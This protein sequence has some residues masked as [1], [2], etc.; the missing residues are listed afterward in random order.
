MAKPIHLKDHNIDARIV[1]RR[2]AL[3][4]VF[5][6]ALVGALVARMYYL[7][8]TQ[9]EHHSTLSEN[10]RVHV[11][12]IPPTRGRIY[13][14]NGVVLAE[15]RP[16][17][18]L[19]ITRDRVEDLPATFELLRSLLALND[20]DLAQ[21]E[22]RLSQARRPFESVP[23]MFEL[24]Q[25]QIARIAI[26]QFRLPGVEVQASF[27]RYYPYA[28]HFAHALGY[29]GRINEQELKSIDPVAYAGT[30]YIGKTG[31][32]RFYEQLL[33]G[34]VGYE[35]VETNARG[36]VL[37][38]L[39]RTE[40]VSGSDLTL[41]LDAELQA[42]AEEALGDRRGAVVAIDPNTGGVL[43]FVS[44]PGFDP[45]LFV[46]GISYA[47]YG[48]LRD[49]LD[50][51]LF[52]RVLRGQ[53]PPGSTIKPIV[54]L[55]GLDAGVVT[56]TSRVYD[57]GFYQL[58]NVS[59]KYR[60]WNRAGDGW[61]DMPYAIARSNDTYFYDLAHK[62]GIDRLHDF[63]SQF[64]IGQRVSID[65]YEEAAGLM[66][67]R[68]W[69]RGRHRQPWYPGETL[70]AGIGQGYMLATPLQLAQATALIASRGVWHR[71]RLLK[72]AEGLLPD[73]S[74]TPPDI[75]IRNDSDWDFITQAM[76]DVMQSQHG[77]ARAAAAGAPYNMAGKSGTAQVVA[78]A[79][80]ERYDSAA[81]RERHRD[82][83]L[84]VG[85]APTEKPMIAVA[86]LVENGESGGRV[87][88]PVVR[89]VFDAWVLPRLPPEPEEGAADQENAP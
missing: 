58:P 40:P 61:V 57:P 86:A 82:H 87:A 49:S 8:V 43:A 64:G 68:D 32:E 53:Y 3:A 4:A 81:L 89:A 36:R 13:D 73:E 60:N 20:E 77:T 23:V 19:T 25:E 2:L 39:K 14:R 70:I 48:A 76:Q 17:Y 51:P 15:N 52:N 28:D 84:F 29:V 78:I 18:S 9:Y 47:D 10:N 16:S 62:L 35:E 6:V 1:Q 83:A 45:N 44:K 75:Q 74:D 24:T 30:H 12:P 37:R 41:E 56:R 38:V 69:K 65:M 26:N 46:T 66:P 50:Q 79:Q 63:M 42:V 85:F 11:Q 72:E 34:T 21:A 71:P 67:S 27:V 55:A 54:A 7:Q 31:I 22:R 80:G 33:H 5:V 59:H 88:G